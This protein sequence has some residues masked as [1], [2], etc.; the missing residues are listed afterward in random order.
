MLQ[1]CHVDLCRPA[2]FR[3]ACWFSTQILTN[4]LRWLTDSR[5]TGSLISS[6]LLQPRGL[7]TSTWCGWELKGQYFSNVFNKMGG[8]LW[9]ETSSYF[10]S[11]TAVKSKLTQHVESLITNEKPLQIYLP[12]SGRILRVRVR[13]SFSQCLNNY[14]FF[15][16]LHQ[17]HN[18]QI[19]FIW[20]RLDQDDS[21]LDFMSP[22]TQ[23][24]FPAAKDTFH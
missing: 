11:W 13:L 24:L 16:D 15:T 20:A 2:Y 22:Q 3:A 23:K 7:H 12:I 6:A 21:P 14:C 10:Q 5:L 17:K 8:Q 9:K 1:Q 19:V 4:I 18:T